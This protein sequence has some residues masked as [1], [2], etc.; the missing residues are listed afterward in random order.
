MEDYIC[1]VFVEKNTSIDKRKGIIKSINKF[2]RIIEFTKLKGRDLNNWIEKAFKKY[3]KNISYNNIN[4]FIQHSSYFNKDINKSLYDLENEVIKLVNFTGNRKEINVKD[5]DRVMTKS[6]DT[7]IFNLLNSIGEK[8]I[9][10][11]L[12]V[13]HEM[14]ISNEPIPLILHMIIRQLRLILML[15]LLKEK[16]YN[17]GTIIGKLK[18]GDYQYKIFSN[19]SKN[20]SK[21]KLEES[22]N[23]CLESD[24]YIKTGMINDKL[25]LEILI[26]KMCS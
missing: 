2:G 22:L 23:L 20:F 1:L 9:N 21:V 17:K 19:Q 5:I 7:N 3:G 8:D 15:K 24:K 11:S 25:A 6:L 10:N 12:K 18:I 14:C 13:F 26:V 4:Y 16:G